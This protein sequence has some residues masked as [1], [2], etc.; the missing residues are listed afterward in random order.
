M[1]RRL[2]LK[3]YT[4]IVDFGTISE[5]TR[6][7]ICNMLR[8]YLKNE[9]NLTV[10]EMGAF[11][12]HSSLPVLAF[13]KLTIARWSR[14]IGLFGY[15]SVSEAEAY[16]K[17]PYRGGPSATIISQRRFYSIVGLSPA[18]TPQEKM[19]GKEIQRLA[20]KPI[21]LDLGR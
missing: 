6:S 8:E 10:D 13:G 3:D 2:K 20:K 19:T 18:E 21:K 12:N 4:Y 16:I 7:S 14:S 17:V 11:E 1:S 9:H 15:T 5:D